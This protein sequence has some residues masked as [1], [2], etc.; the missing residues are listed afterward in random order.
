MAYAFTLEL[1]GMAGVRSMR[2]MNPTNPFVR[3]SIFHK[4][5]TRKWFVRRGLRTHEVARRGLR[6]CEKFLTRGLT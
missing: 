3:V 4:E 2:S 6:R 1:P 5:F